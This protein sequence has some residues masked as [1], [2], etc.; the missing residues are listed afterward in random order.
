MA[1][2]NEEDEEQLDPN[3]PQQ[4][5]ESATIG[6]SAGGSAA[7]AAEAG[8]TAAADPKKQSNFVGISQYINANKPQSEKLAGQVAGNVNDKAAMVDTN[9]GETENSF[10]QAADAQKVNVDTGLFDEVKTNAQGVAGDAAKKSSFD[11]AKSASYAGPQNLNETGNWGALQASLNKAK[12]AKAATGTEEGRMGLIKEVS[13]NPRQSQGALT[14]DNLLLQSNPNSAGVLQGAGAGLNDIDQ[15]LG[16]AQSNAAS[17][18]KEVSNMNAATSAAAKGALGEGYSGLKNDLTQR[19]AAKDA[20]QLAYFNK[21]KETLA[22]GKDPSAL[23][24]FGIDPN[25][26]NFGVSPAAFLNYQDGADIY[27]VA[28]NEDLARQEALKSLAGDMDLGGDILSGGRKL[29]ELGKGYA[30]D[31]AG[32]QSAVTDKQ[33]QSTDLDAAMAK[34]QSNFDKAQEWYLEDQ[35]NGKERAEKGGQSY[36]DYHKASLELERLRQQQQELQKKSKASTAS[37]PKGSL[38]GPR[39]VGV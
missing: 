11:K 38:T 20:E 16:T 22:S 27:G 39:M 29:G 12:Q 8:A 37:A 14:F 32:Y 17:K 1:F 23:A 31:T 24:E 9:L 26:Q 30:F 19:E 33:A 25:S 36:E 35:G 2:Y 7:G 21:L 6:G 5:G 34:A 13:N 10:N 15:R 3:A 4:T 18:A 28:G